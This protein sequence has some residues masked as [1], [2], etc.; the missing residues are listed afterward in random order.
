MNLKDVRDSLVECINA[1]I[2]AFL[3]GAPGIGK[4][5]IVKQIG[6]ELGLP[7]IDLRA[8]LLDPVDLRGL[9]TVH[10]G[11]A[12][13]A[14]P[15][16][17]PRADRD[18]PRGLLML[19]ELNAAPP[20]TQAACFQ[21]VLDRRLGE[22]VMPA[23]WRIVAAGNRQT[24]RAAAQ[25]MPTPLANRFAHF[26]VEADLES[27]LE[28]ADRANVNPVIAAFVKHK[29]DLLH[30][31]DGSDMIRFPTPRAWAQVSK[32]SNVANEGLRR[33]L[34]EAIVGEAAATE[35]CSFI[36]MFLSLPP[37]DSIIA[38][39]TSA[40]VRSEPSV[41]HLITTAL[42]RK[43]TAANFV[44]ILTY[45]AR[46]PAEHAVALVQSAVKRDPALKETQ[47]FI[48]WKLK[49]QDIDF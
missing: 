47:A 32:V 36:N 35:C 14:Q 43:A 10:N 20:S 34:I 4:S 39:P 6:A 1:D 16:F 21:L 9:P 7:V 25:K 22:Y 40:P 23:G 13:W 5:D 11:R 15:D 48:A 26:T 42:A 37:L 12:Q 28:W 49:N 27:W 2:P 44:A 45:A 33:N 18:G 31:M 29:P 19:D 46:L 17:L 8:I 30:K 41:M 38:N 24:D 3:W